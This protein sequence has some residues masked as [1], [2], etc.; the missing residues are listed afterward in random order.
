MSPVFIGGHQARQFQTHSQQ[1]LEA[2][3]QTGWG[4]KEVYRHVLAK[5]F[6]LALLLINHCVIFRTNS[7]KP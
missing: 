1:H 7:C 2:Q 4:Q 3:S 5:Q 6:M